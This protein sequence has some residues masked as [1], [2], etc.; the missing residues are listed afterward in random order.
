MGFVVTSILGRQRITPARSPTVKRSS[1]SH[2]SPS[3]EVR[4]YCSAKHSHVPAV[5]RHRLLLS[6]TGALEGVA[7][8]GLPAS[9]ST[10]FG[11]L[12]DDAGCI[13]DVPSQSAE[14]DFAVAAGSVVPVSAQNVLEEVLFTRHAPVKFS[15][16]VLVLPLFLVS[17]DGFPRSSQHC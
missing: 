2:F 5:V 16:F 17:G 8:Q 7:H 1:E 9:S 6:A 11:F 3:C 13:A 15:L 10:L 12:G 4:L 14:T